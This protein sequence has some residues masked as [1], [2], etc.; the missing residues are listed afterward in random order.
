MSDNQAPVEAPA[1]SKD[2]AK[3]TAVRATSTVC[4]LLHGIR[5]RSRSSRAWIVKY[6]PSG[7][8]D[9]GMVEPEE[10]H[11]PEE[12]APPVFQVWN[13]VHGRA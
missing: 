7:E 12:V 9:E 13:G 1:D 6:L 11:F 5:R 3:T 10:E 8:A 2:F 4:L